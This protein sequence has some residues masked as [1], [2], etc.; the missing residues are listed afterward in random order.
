MQQE[1]Q[2]KLKRTGRT[3]LGFVCL[4]IGIVF[5]LL[6]GPAVIFLPLGLALLSVEYAWAKIWLKRTQRYF[7]LAAIK[8]DQ[9]LHWLGRKL[10]G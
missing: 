5:M 10:R 2:K 9:G 8:A 1:L 7:R 6:P 4:F 3:I